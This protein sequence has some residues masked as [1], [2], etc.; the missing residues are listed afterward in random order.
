[1]TPRCR[2]FPTA[3]ESM[4]VFPAPVGAMPAVFPCLSRALT[5]R[6]TKT[7][8]LGRNRIGQ[9]GAA[10]AAP[11]HSYRAHAGRLL[12]AAA[13]PAAGAFAP[14]AGAGPRAG[15]AARATGAP[16]SGTA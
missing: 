2:N 6:S 1:S 4:M 14:H 11:L 7:C 10:E 12:A 16:P 3:A 5:Q 9:D 13:G 15:A 8:C